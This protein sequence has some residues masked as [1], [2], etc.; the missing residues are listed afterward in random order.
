M[1]ERTC[2]RSEGRFC[3]ASRRL[4]CLTGYSLVIQPVRPRSGSV[5]SIVRTGSLEECDDLTANLRIKKRTIRCKPQYDLGFFKRC[6]FLEAFEDVLDPS[7]APPRLPHNPQ[8]AYRCHCRS[9]DNIIVDT[10]HG[11]RRTNDPS[12][13][14]T[15]IQFSP[16]L[17]PAIGSTSFGLV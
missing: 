15:A 11:I 17:C 12:Q 13:K 2:S 4:Q 7:L 1:Y 9:R 14:R 3:F 8:L 16:E 10:W 5:L 6:R